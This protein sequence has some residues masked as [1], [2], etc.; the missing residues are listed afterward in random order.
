VVLCALGIAV[1]WTAAFALNGS[2]CSEGISGISVTHTRSRSES[3]SDGGG[4]VVRRK[5]RRPTVSL[6]SLTTTFHLCVESTGLEP[7][8]D[9]LTGCAISAP[10]ANVTSS[11]AIVPRMIHYSQASLHLYSYTLFSYGSRRTYGSGCTLTSSLPAACARHHCTARSRTHEA[12][13]HEV[14]P[15]EATPHLAASTHRTRLRRDLGNHRRLIRVH[16]PCL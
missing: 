1:S 12:A 2:L 7:T 15:H 9:R 4:R 14:A 11:A 8:S 10:R 13:P 5:Y 3:E 16:S 6:T